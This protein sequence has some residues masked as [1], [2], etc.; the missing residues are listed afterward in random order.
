MAIAIPSSRP[1]A[2]IASSNTDTV[3]VVQTLITG[4]LPQ[5]TTTDETV[6]AS[7]TIAAH[8]VVGR[9]TATKAIIPCVLTANDGSQVPI[10]IAP[11]AISTGSG[12]TTV[13]PIY[14]SGCY[15]PDVLVWDASFDTAAKKMAAFEGAPTPTNIVLRAAKTA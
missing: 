10:G 15:N 14:R 3:T 8:A 7:T 5:I 12:E 6:G 2:G 13:L 4:D 1:I 11:Y 9:I